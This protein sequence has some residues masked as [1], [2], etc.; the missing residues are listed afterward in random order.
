MPATAQAQIRATI[1]ATSLGHAQSIVG[2]IRGDCQTCQAAYAAMTA[3][4]ARLSSYDSALSAYV[5]KYHI[6]KPVRVKGK[7]VSPPAAPRRPAAQPE[8]PPQPSAP[9]TAGG[10]S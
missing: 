5:K 3:Y 10:T 8:C 6:A 7:L 2:T 4:Q 1:P 9:G